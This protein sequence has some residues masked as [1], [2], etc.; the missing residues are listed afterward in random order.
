[1]KSMAI[2]VS[3]NGGPDV[4]EYREIDVPPPGSGEVQI[5]QAAIGLNFIDTYFRSGLYPAPNGFPYIAGEEGAGTVIAVGPDLRDIH[6]GD[7]IAYPAAAG[8]YADVRN[9]V[10]AKIV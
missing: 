3:R 10:A 8:A 7:R 4:L 6:E 9:I 5:R 2:L 1:M